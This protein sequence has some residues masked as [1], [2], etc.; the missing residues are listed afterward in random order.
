MGFRSQD[1]RLE[2]PE[3]YI[4]ISQISPNHVQTGASPGLNF[5]KIFHEFFCVFSMKGSVPRISK[6]IFGDLGIQGFKGS[7]NFKGSS[8]IIRNFKGIMGFSGILRDFKV[9]KGILSDL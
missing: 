4:P 9:F 8:S 6:N 3:K 2:S 5:S 1:I 7:R